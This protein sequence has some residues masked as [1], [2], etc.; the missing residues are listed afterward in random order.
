VLDLQTIVSREINPVEP[1]VVTVGSIHGGAKHNII[2]DEVRLQL[3]VR[4]YSPG[5]RK[6]IADAIRR[7]AN[8]AAQSAGAPE[9]EVDVSEGTPSLYNDPTLT[10][11]VAKALEQALGEENVEPSEP[12]MG[13]EDFSRYGIAGVP[14]CM[15]KLGSIRPD[16]LAELTEGGA[17]APSLHSPLYWPDPEPTLKTGVRAMA[18]IVEELLPPQ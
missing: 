18:A 15:F 13:G 5:V 4:S 11:R 7:K 17:L 3:T 10:G 1:A 12:T 16:R 8:A 6:Q 2:G 9:P 14:I